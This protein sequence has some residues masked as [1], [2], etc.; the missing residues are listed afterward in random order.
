MFFGGK[1]WKLG[2]SGQD[3]RKETVVGWGGEAAIAFLGYTED[4]AERNCIRVEHV[5]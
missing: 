4:R 1:G 3:W 5:A 2:G